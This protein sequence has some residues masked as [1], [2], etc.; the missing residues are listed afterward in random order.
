[1]AKRKARDKSTVQ[2]KDYRAPDTTNPTRPEVGMQARYN[3]KS[4]PKEYRYDSSLSPA[5]E[6]DSGNP[7]REQAE[8]LIRQILDAADLDEAKAAAEKL[9]RMSAPFLNWAGKAERQAF[10]VPTLPL[11]IH[12][13]LSTTAIVEALRSHRRAQ[14]KTLFDLFADPQHAIVDLTL[15]SSASV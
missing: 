4:P 12:G 6:W 11:F 5:L 9:R 10:D 2:V 14:Q 13:R 1:V 15:C 3:K 7:A 8:A